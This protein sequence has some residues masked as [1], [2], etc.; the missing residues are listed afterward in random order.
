M[1]ENIFLFEEVK[2]T[3]KKRNRSNIKINTSKDAYEYICKIINFD[4]LIEEVFIV[5]Y[6]NR[7]CHIIGWYICSVGGVAGTVVDAKKIFSTGLNCLSSHAIFCHNHPSGSLIPSDADKK[8][9]IKLIESGKL[10]DIEVI[11]HLI[12]GNQEYL[13]FADEGILHEKSLSN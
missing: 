5:I 10:L 7:S 1:Q 3:W 2:T 6:L 8:L 13:S 11:D 4:D 9:T 12:I